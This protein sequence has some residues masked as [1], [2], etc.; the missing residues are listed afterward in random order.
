MR[1]PINIQPLLKILSNRKL[2]T[3]DAVSAAQMRQNTHAGILIRAKEEG[4]TVALL[5]AHVAHAM[6]STLPGTGGEE[7]EEIGNVDDKGVGF[8]LHGDPDAVWVQDLEGWV[9]SA[10][11]ADEGEE[12][13]IRVCAYAD[14][15]GALLRGVV[16]GADVCQGVRGDVVKVR[17][18]E[19]EGEGEDAEEAFAEG[20]HG[21]VVAVEGWA[22]EEGR[23]VRGPLVAWGL[24]RGRRRRG[25]EGE[26]LGVGEVFAHEEAFFEI[27]IGQGKGGCED[28][29]WEE[30]SVGV[31]VCLPPR[32][33][34]SSFPSRNAS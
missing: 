20:E 34:G 14:V 31:C 21:A 24:G 15:G 23:R 22:P 5:A 3:H 13:E 7:L 10:G 8:V 1:P 17:L 4:H 6:H 12:A 30:Q 33:L 29:V 32:V 11:L 19:V 28:L 26:L 2:A 9:R 25:D 16:H 18:R 27:Y